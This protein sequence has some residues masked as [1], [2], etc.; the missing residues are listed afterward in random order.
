MDKFDLVEQFWSEC[1][2]VEQVPGKVSGALV[3]KGTRVPVSA[4]FNNIGHMNITEFTSQFPVDKQQ[5]QTVLEYISKLLDETALIRKRDISSIVLGDT[6]PTLDYISALLNPKFQ[7]CGIEKA[8]V[9]GSRARGDSCPHSDLDLL[10][11]AD[12]PVPYHE[13]LVEFKDIILA[14]VKENSCSIDMIVLTPQEWKDTK[15]K[16]GG[17]ASSV[18]KE[19]ILIYG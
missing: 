9:F 8:I 2:A 15:N 10:V 17:F 7:E 4:L 13:R 3:F 1:D 14:W 18:I 6:V 19:G 16:Q 12:T 11:I 5:A